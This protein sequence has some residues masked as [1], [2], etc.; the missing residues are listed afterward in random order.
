MV[1]RPETIRVL[2]VDDEPDFTDLAAT[3]L[4]RE[5][6]R[7]T[8]ETATNAEHGLEVLD[9]VEV[10]CIVS[11][12]EMPGR[13]GIEFLETVRET[14]PD[15]PFILYTGRGSEEVASE[16]ISVGVTEYMQKEGG[17]DQYAVLA[18]RIANSVDQYRARQEA[19]RTRKRLTELSESTTDCLWM[20]D[21]DWEKLIFI[22]GYEDVWNRSES[23]IR[24]DP[25]DFLNGVHPDDRDMVRDAMERLSNGEKIDIEY[26]ILRGDAQQGAVWVKGEPVFDDNGTVVRVVGFTRDITDRREQ[27][28]RLETLIS[29]LPGI[30]YRCR[31]ELGW[32]M[33]FVRGECETLTGY[34]AEA[35]ESGDVDWSED[36]L[37]PDDAD[38][39]WE[40]VQNAV[41]AERP[42]EVTYRIRTK[43]GDIRWMW[44]R[45]RLV[46]ATVE[47]T[48]ILE[49]FITDIT[50][51]KRREHE[52]ERYEAYLEQS[53]DI[54]TVLDADGTIK[55]QSP[56]VTR[57]LGYGPGE[58]L[59]RNGFEYIHPE[60]VAAI[61]AAFDNLLEE[62]AETVSVECR[63]RTADGEWRWLE[64]NGSNHLDTDPINGIVT[65]NRDITDR[66]EREQELE[67]TTAILST[68][69]ETLPVG[70]LAEDG[71]RNVLATN[72][73]LFELFDLPGTPAEV[74]G[75]DCEEM[76]RTVSEQFLDPE[77]FVGRIDE[78]VAEET[79]PVTEE[80][81]R[82][83]GRTF[84]RTYKPIELPSGDGHLWVY[85]DVTAQTKRRETLESVLDEMDDAIFVHPEEGSFTFV[86]QAAVERYGFS[87][88][89]LLTMTPA[90][91]NVDVEPATVA[92]RVQEV[93]AAGR[94]VF[95]TEHRTRSGE[96]I[97]VEINATTV[98]FHGESS[99]LSIVRD[100]TERKRAER[101]FRKTKER[102]DL[103][104]E[105][106][107]LGVWDWNMLTD[108]VEYNAQW[109]E[110]LGYTLDDI[111]PHLDAWESR[112]HPDDKEAV[113]A[114]LDAHIEGETDYYDTEHR[115]RT[116][117]GDWKWIRDIGKVVERTSEGEPIRAVGI[118]VD[119]TDQK[120]RERELQQH[121]DRLNRFISVISHDLRNPLHVAS[122]RIELARETADSDSLDDAADA[123]ERSLAL[124]DDLL[125]LAREGEQ[126]SDL[127][128]TD[129]G[130]TA[131]RCW[132]TVLTQDATLRVEAEQTIDTDPGRLK[133]LFENLFTN[134]VEHGG[135]D[136][137][138]T[139][140]DLDD[141]FYV[142]DDG[143]G[144]QEDDRDEVFDPGF[145]TGADGTGFGLSIV[146]EIVDA[147]G[148]EIRVT[149]SAAGGARF[150]IT[151]VETSENR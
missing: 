87:E 20:F 75:A 88:E 145:S 69:I 48:E 111:E 108:A 4:E 38:R 44:E 74:V 6:D 70:V 45:G 41:D 47:N 59:G 125:A 46:D 16:A 63:F 95:E 109:A 149:E 10:D 55:Y 67:R 150:E 86:N 141:G 68:L 24:D 53:T 1:D 35:I 118:H 49:G 101:E 94:S 112:V 54:V 80:L 37:H 66:K 21:R 2:H 60:D 114:V 26:R 29:N 36:V 31:N 22:S 62:P 134:A 50:E 39:M 5:D 28:R 106:T 123:I 133:Q 91:L 142:A 127:E 128:P 3:F 78:L 84:E 32:P 131:S 42:F 30:V 135:E 13:N 98:T 97:P 113:Q 11:D 140:D 132:E 65:N 82:A 96:T 122:G 8:V 117:E 27:R 139:V 99:I 129:L 147:H 64:V 110:M 102:L 81:S 119:I 7:F 71:A 77:R 72:E 89:E 143:V 83:D 105:G 58:L 121:N 130:T 14:H 115:M 136:V 40:R 79:S 151:G 100:I 137:T 107:G 126:A 124:I 9:S 61:E 104:V 25:R 33:E 92:E 120:R 146:K 90:D 148:W 19:E 103:V 23:A 43:D 85:R 52:L 17:T 51:R 144:I 116:A 12:Y 15:L 18:N 76:A 73:R 56:A 34:T 57:I 138:V 93:M